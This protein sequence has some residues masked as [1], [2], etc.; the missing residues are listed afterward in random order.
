MLLEFEELPQPGVVSIIIPCYN[1]E[2]FLSETLE[3]ALAQS[4]PHSEIIVID[5]GST[6]GTAK[7]IRSYAD[8]LRA[9]SGPNRGAS[10]ARNRGT[11]LARGEFIQYLD[12][13]DL[14]TQ[15]AV[16][17]RVA[18]LQRSGAD[19]AYSDWERLVE[20]EPS[21]FELGK[22]VTRRIEDVHPN[23]QIALLTS[24]WAPP[25]AITYRRSIVGK[26]GGWKEWLPIIQDAR[27]LQDAA[28]VG[29]RFIYVPG[30]GARYREHLG[31]SL[32]RHSNAAFVTD[33]F[34]NACDLQNLFERRGDMSTEQCQA[35]AQIYNYVARS[36][37]F[38]DKF[39]F[40]DCIRRLYQVEPGFRPS[41]PKAARLAST[42]FGFHAA[43][44]L[45]AALDALRGIPQRSLRKPSAP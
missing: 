33:V 17:N 37:F 13:D 23:V 40:H 5:D 30:V 25:A 38:Y 1:S 22:Q 14:L 32:S 3:S 6:D 7:L 20:I 11:V 24:F 39:A 10:G 15:N 35:L 36:L 18:T 27:F 41:W 44:I 29:A 8:R 45:L 26:I 9:D 28:L 42:M 16:A 21:V 43:G 19:V 4:Y 34:R 31:A 12:A 2:R